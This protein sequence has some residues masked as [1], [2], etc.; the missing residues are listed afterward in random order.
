V[1]SKLR[2]KFQLI[3]CAAVQGMAGP[4]GG[5][6]LWRHRKTGKVHHEALAVMSHL[7]Y[8]RGAPRSAGRGRGA[9][10]YLVRSKS[11]RC[12]PANFVQ[13]TRLYSERCPVYT[14]FTGAKPNRLSRRLMSRPESNR[15]GGRLA[16]FPAPVA[17]LESG[18]NELWDRSIIWLSLSQNGDGSCQTSNLPAKHSHACP[19][20]L[21]R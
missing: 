4:G 5:R 14:K 8:A 16:A 19:L 18:R 3:N 13:A 20:P 9:T 10:R 2:S 17:D 6:S 21:L 7:G 1:H 12:S 11:F 15:S